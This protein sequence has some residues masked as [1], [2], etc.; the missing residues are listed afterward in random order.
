LRGQDLVS[1]ATIEWQKALDAA[2]NRKEAL[3]MLFR[4]ASE[5]NWTG[6]AEELV[7]TL[8][9]NYPGEKWATAAL[10]KT[11]LTEGRTRS[12][13]GLYNQQASTNPS[14]LSARN[15]LAMTALLLNAWEL[16]P[17][18]LAREVYRQAPANPA[19]A[20][21]YALSLHLQDKNENALQ[22]L[23]R[24]ATPQLED[25]AVA[26]CYGVILQATGHAEQARR[27]LELA[28]K[29]RLLPEERKLVWEARASTG[30]A[31][32]GHVAR[33]KS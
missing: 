17:H 10:T 14:D 11:L 7:W 24:L 16:R 33:G 6:Q 9:R 22:V 15:N 1:S 21:T 8:V 13:M 23:Q 28:S 27:Y 2:S 18:D 25:P 4:F 32:F 26:A 19:Y 30:S 3:V 12:L 20:S 29:G 5:W 31:S